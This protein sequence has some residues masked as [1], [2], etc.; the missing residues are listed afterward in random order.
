MKYFLF[1]KFICKCEYFSKVFKMNLKPLSASDKFKQFVPYFKVKVKLMVHLA[2]L[3]MAKGSPYLS[4]LISHVV[5]LIRHV[6][7]LTRERG[8]VLKLSP[9]LAAKLI[10]LFGP[11]GFHISP[12]KLLSIHCYKKGCINSLSLNCFISKIKLKYL[13]CLEKDAFVFVRSL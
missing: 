1:E 10:Q 7:L 4:D 5:I 11:V 6:L 8:L 9:V 12:G 3:L 13:K 2:L